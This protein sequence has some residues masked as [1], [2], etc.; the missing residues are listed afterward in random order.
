MLLP[1]PPRSRAAYQAVWLPPSAWDTWEGIVGAA[2]CGCAC[3]LQGVSPPMSASVPCGMVGEALAPVFDASRSF[4]SAR[5]PV[6]TQTLSGLSA[7][8]ASWRP[9]SQAGS[10][11]AARSWALRL[12]WASQFCC[13]DLGCGAGGWAVGAAAAGLPAL[14]GLDG[15]PTAVATYSLNNPTHAVAVQDVCDVA[16]VCRR[17]AV[18]LTLARERRPIILLCSPPCQPHSLAGL[19]AVAGDPRLQVA[20]AMVRI[21]LRLRVA[22]ILFENVEPFA[23]SPQWLAASSA[24]LVSFLS[25]I[26]C[27]PSRSSISLAAWQSSRKKGS[28]RSDASSTHGGASCEISTVSCAV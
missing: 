19:G 2:D 28:A 17:I 23:T 4:R 10:W 14:G 12:D 22:A 26:T 16:A 20:A 18:W 25:S 24:L 27:A 9:P 1:P 11:L 13:V 7:A 5:A 15:C 8:A 6:A 21:A 3:L